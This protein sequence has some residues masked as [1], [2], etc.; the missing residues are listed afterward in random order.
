[1]L[2]DLDPEWD[3]FEI[4]DVRFSNSMVSES[5]KEE[6]FEVCIEELNDYHLEKI[7]RHYDPADT[8]VFN[9]CETLPGIECS[10]RKVVEIIEG[11]GFTC[12]GNTAGVIEL[13]YDK[14]RV[15]E[16]LASLGIKVPY[17][18]VL[19]PEE[20][21]GWNLFPAIVKPSREHCSLT[22]TEKSVVYDTASLRE[23]ILYVN[24][25]LKQPAMV[26]D[27]IDGREFHV[28]VWNNEIPEMLPPAEMDFSA[29][30][31]ARERLCTYDS[32]FRPGSLHYEKI[33]TLI[34]APLTE[35]Q[36]EKLEKTV[37]KTWREFGCRDY[38]RF[39]F[40]LRDNDFFLLDINPNN[41]ISADTS[42]ALAAEMKNYSYGRM[43]K[44]IAMMA[45]GRHSLLAGEIQ[46]LVWAGN[47]SGNGC[48]RGP[49]HLKS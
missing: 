29:F 26:E 16:C 43:V 4:R 25:L 3:S 12:T 18:A 14:L 1:M 19:A 48:P 22:I 36:Y 46:E 8:I 49:G 11:R 10:E 15:K 30:S 47:G 17:G 5:L 28:S 13:S 20:A 6:G 21:G 2:Y 44:R 27:F 9:L 35:R 41:D 37:L 40:R 7:L 39:D 34:P 33:E 24:N 38:A 23:Q 32:K 45:A 42:F 31:E